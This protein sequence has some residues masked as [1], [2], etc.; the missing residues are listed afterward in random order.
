MSTIFSYDACEFTHDGSSQGLHRYAGQ[1]RLTP[2]PPASPDEKALSLERLKQQLTQTGAVLL[3]HYYTE[4]EIQDLA[5]A[6]QGCVGDSLEMARFGQA[7]T[8][9]T[10]VVAGVHFMAETAKILSPEK[11]VLICHPDSQCSLDLGC[12][13][14]DF[15]AFCDQHPERVVVVYANTSAA[16]KARADWVVTSS[17]ALEIVSHL[18]AQGKKILW[19]PDRHLGAY[20]QQQTGADML[21][22]QGSCLVHDEFKAHELQLLKA[23][24]PHAQVLAHP[25]SPAA[26]LA[27]ADI[28]GS[29]SQMIRAAKEGQATTYIVATDQGILHA[30]RLQA[31]NKHF[32]AAPTAGNSASCKSC[33]FCPWMGLNTLHQ[34]EQT[35]TDQTQAIQIDPRLASQARQSL[36][37]ML[38][39]A[40]QRE[41]SLR[42]GPD[43]ADHMHLFQHVGPA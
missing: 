15:N 22:W 23:R 39:F 25:E 17:I 26:V 32:L 19:A 36:Q 43:L 33:A 18:H 27:L 6:T 24:Y 1:I 4:P 9:Q 38:Q 13:I 35:L 29:T 21:L 20:V 28:V 3:A 37:R 12:P 14:E 10:L 8:A 41:Q 2:P 11:T 16:V 31:P 5:L 30:M 7:H 34:L 42:L 40:N